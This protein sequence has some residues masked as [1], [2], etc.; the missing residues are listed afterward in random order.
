MCG[1]WTKRSHGHVFVPVLE[2]RH[3]NRSSIQIFFEFFK[4]R[5][6]LREVSKVLVTKADFRSEHTLQNLVSTLNYLLDANIVPILNT[7]DAIS[8]P[9]EATQDVANAL[10]INDNDSLAAKL[11]TLLKSDLLLLM[12]DVDGVYDRHP[13]ET[14]ARLLSSFV[15]QIHRPIISFGGKS[16]VG[17]GG[18][19]SKINAASFAVDN[20]CSVIICN[21]KLQ[22]AIVDSVR[23]K[24]VGTFFTNNLEIN[25]LSVE[26]MALQ[27]DLKPDICLA[28]EKLDS[29][30]LKLEMV[31]DCCRLCRLKKEAKLSPTTPKVYSITRG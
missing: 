14:D 16:D 11:A 21:G 15:P 29:V 19:E 13:S 10:N 20:D 3:R 31:E 7:N 2:L 5:V 12:S 8:Y 4:D 27:G 9:P 28:Y 26:N 18:M 25:S 30:Y 22:N 1:G 24:K 23:G 6:T 17:T